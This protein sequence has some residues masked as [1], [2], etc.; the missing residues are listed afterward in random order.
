M[1]H[2]NS[3]LTFYMSKNSTL[4]SPISHP[5]SLMLFSPQSFFHSQKANNRL[6]TQITPFLLVFL[7]L[8]GPPPPSTPPLAPSLSMSA[9]VCSL[10]ETIL[11][12][13]TLLKERTLTPPS[14]PPSHP[15]QTS[16]TLLLSYHPVNPLSPN[17][18]KFS[19][20]P[21]GNRM[22][23]YLLLGWPLPPPPAMFTLYLEQLQ[24]SALHLPPILWNPFQFPLQPHCLQA[25][26]II[27]ISYKLYP[28]PSPF[29]Q[30]LA[31]QV[32]IFQLGATYA[33]P[34]T[35]STPIVSII[36]AP[37]ADNMHQATPTTSVLNFIAPTVSNMITPT[38]SA[39]NYFF[40]S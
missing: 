3:P 32:Q 25:W 20:I 27:S 2:E 31:T 19:L 18:L 16:P 23:S 22:P 9:E 1:R 8:K 21:Y 29:P 4:P 17:L 10:T 24:N 28:L 13:E 34:L 35:T 15:L 11:A 12:L 38:F 36:V 7:E 40:Q 26:M 5:P 14:S 37:P 39:P 33:G 6:S 30:D